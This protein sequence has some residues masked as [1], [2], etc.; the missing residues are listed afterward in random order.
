[1]CIRDRRKD[2]SSS[3][4]SSESTPRRRCASG[5]CPTGNQSDLRTLP[6]RYT[7]ARVLKRDTPTY[8]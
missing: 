1:M 6:N 7:P 2:S 5:P 4:V 3:N 8:A